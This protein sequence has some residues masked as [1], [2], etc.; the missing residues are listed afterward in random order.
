MILSR[1][2]CVWRQSLIALLVSSGLA[3]ANPANPPMLPENGPWTSGDYVQA[4]FAVQ[5]GV[6]TLPR[7]GNPKTKAYFDRLVDRGNVDHLMAATLAPAEKRGDILIILSATGE[8]RGRYGYAVALGD[9]VHE[10]LVDL[11]IFRLFLIDRLAM[12]DKQD[13]GV[14]VRHGSAIATA[15]SGTLDTL[16]EDQKFTNDQ[17]VALSHA[18]A[19]HYP[20]IRTKLAPEEQR[21]TM[22]R[23]AA[24]VLRAKDPALRSAL[25]GALAAA[26]SP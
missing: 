12:L 16:T 15:L 6:I 1:F 2:Q 26:R 25:S 20:V 7:Q 10:E 17:L 21:E 9:D 5:N 22:R 8:F 18:L 3:G 23:L 19:R 4:I 14:Q 13:G 24:I 11:Q